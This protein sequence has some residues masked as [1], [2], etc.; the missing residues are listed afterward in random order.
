MSVF[1]EGFCVDDD[2]VNVDRDLSSVDEVSEYVVH[3]QL[4][5]RG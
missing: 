2:V 4:E 1:F 5:R 3:Y